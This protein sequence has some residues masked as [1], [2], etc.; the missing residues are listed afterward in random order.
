MAEFERREISLKELGELFP[1]HDKEKYFAHVKRRQLLGSGIIESPS[2]FDG[3]HS[4]VPV[5]M[6]QKKYLALNCGDI[7]WISD[8]GIR[9]NE[10]SYLRIVWHNVFQVYY[11]NKPL[12][13][14]RRGENIS[15]SLD[16]CFTFVQVKRKK[17]E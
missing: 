12:V 6:F 7:G 14:Q 9:D 10:L 1:E 4:I 11:E 2:F 17:T 3:Y 16:D 15:V 13:L 8:V 5:G